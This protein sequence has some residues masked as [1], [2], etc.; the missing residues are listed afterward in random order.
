[1][2]QDDIKNSA[3]WKNKIRFN[4]L[5]TLLVIIVY[6]L[7]CAIIGF[8]IDILRGMIFD[9]LSLTMATKSLI[10][11]GRPAYVA[12]ATTTLSLLA[13][14]FFYG[15][16]HHIFHL[17]LTHELL[18][19]TVK[20]EHE[21]A[22]LQHHQELSEKIGFAH[23]PTLS[24]AEHANVNAFASGFNDKNSTV[25]L[26]RGLIERLTLAEITA[27]L[28]VELYHIKLR[29]TQL[30]QIISFASHGLIV[31]FDTLFYA[32]LYGKNRN[33]HPRFLL[34]CYYR[35]LI[36]IRFMLPSVTFLYRFI[37]SPNRVHDAHAL[38]VQ[39][40]GDN[41]YL[42]SAIL[43]IHAAHRNEKHLTK[44]YSEISHEEIRRES[45]FFDPADFNMV[46]TFSTPFY[47]QPSIE[48]QLEKLQTKRDNAFHY[49]NK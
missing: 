34:S 42:I 3:H 25:V 18:V 24:I 19:H 14:V 36:N 23:V 12:N 41:Q 48:E 6:I 1:M 4:Q 10:L 46:Q 13:I 9:D 28:A 20:N 11:F 7:C 43:K 40:L 38:A 22:I 27:V 45:Y 26:T 39:L 2:H 49:I 32:S 31:F 17:G 33:Q 5:N 29:D 15:C 21:H 47:T 8:S 44:V 16:H 30:T 37:L 35:L